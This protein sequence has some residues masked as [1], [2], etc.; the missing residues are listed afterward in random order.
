MTDHFPGYDVLRKRRTPSWDERTR[1]AINDRLSVPREPRFLSPELF[2][3]LAAACGRIIPQPPDRPP[4]PVAA[5][6]DTKL[7]ESK[8]DGYRF[9]SMPE[10]GEAYR[11]GLR[12]FDDAAQS[13]HGRRFAGLEPAAQDQILASAQKGELDGPAWQGMPSKMFFE[14]RLL[15]DAVSAYYAHPTAW[16][17]M[18]FGGP[19]SPRGYVRMQLNR[20]DPWEAAEAKPGEED[21]VR[22]ENEHV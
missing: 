14:H 21:R 15:I 20:R 7:F 22:W 17:E 11:R 19:A 3:I 16:S 2:A 5:M 1:Q 18:G 6:V 8:R 9:A 4:V 12:G 13:L 10:Q